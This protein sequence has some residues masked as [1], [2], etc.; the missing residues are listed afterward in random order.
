MITVGAA[1]AKAA[2]IAVTTMPRPGRRGAGRGGAG[3]GVAGGAA[4]PPATVVLMVLTPPSER[5]TAVRESAPRGRLRPEAV[6]PP[7]GL[8]VAWPTCRS[9][10]GE[11]SPRSHVGEGLETHP[12]C[13]ASAFVSS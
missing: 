11:S 10:R 4:W 2:Q 9:A 8:Y 6:R 3:R 1:I 5:R 13:G 12:T 7:A